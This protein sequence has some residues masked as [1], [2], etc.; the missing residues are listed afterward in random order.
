[1]QFGRAKPS[2]VRLIV[3]VPGCWLPAKD[4]R[5]RG[6]VT[7]FGSI[8]V[9]PPQLGRPFAHSARL[10][11]ARRLE[12]TLGS[13]SGFDGAVYC[14][15]VHT[16]L[17]NPPIYAAERRPILWHAFH[18]VLRSARNSSHRTTANPPHPGPHT[19]SKPSSCRGGPACLLCTCSRWLP[20]P[21]PLVLLKRSPGGF[22]WGVFF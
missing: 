8:D 19:V 16:C 18:P 5:R 3:D 13:G 4:Q 10:I 14:T 20:D 6:Q 9:S 21:D 1:M 17:S 11:R 15:S 22:F 2:E 12:P 7:M